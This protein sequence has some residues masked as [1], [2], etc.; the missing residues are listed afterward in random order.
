MK[1]REGK[2]GVEDR[3]EGRKNGR[4]EAKKEESIK[5]PNTV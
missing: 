1:M 2:G 4:K 3:R 5:V